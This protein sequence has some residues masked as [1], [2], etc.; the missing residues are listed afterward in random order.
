[1]LYHSVGRLTKTRTAYMKSIT[2]IRHAVQK[3][4]V[5]IHFILLSC[6]ISASSALTMFL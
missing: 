1:M 3:W 4:N 6:V 5:A 2:I